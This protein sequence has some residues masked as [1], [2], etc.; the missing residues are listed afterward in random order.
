MLK[1]NNLENLLIALKDDN[2]VIGDIY[3][4]MYNEVYRYI[5]SIV[6]AKE[7]AQDLTHDTFI[8]IYKNAHLYKGNGHAK[9]WII[10]I[11]RNITYMS[12]RKSSR[13]Q[14]VDYHIDSVDES[15]NDIHD[16]MMIEKMMNILC[17]EEREIIILHVVEGLTFKEISQVM[18]LKLS[19]VL[20]KYH[21]SLKKIRKSL[22][23]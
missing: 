18:D 8:Q 16:K 15:I 1:E 2:R 23:E 11:S 4:L 20:N 13:E 17:Q 6:H 21:R 12:L 3:D 7:Y 14:V 22:E 5:Y 9:A 10:T 19:T